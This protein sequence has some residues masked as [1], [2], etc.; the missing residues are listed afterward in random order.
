VRYLHFLEGTRDYEWLEA[1]LMNQTA[2]TPGSFSGSPAH[3]Q[4]PVAA[5]RLS[6]IHE[7]QVSEV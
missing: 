6:P 2:Q 1:L 7:E 4:V 3:G 5:P